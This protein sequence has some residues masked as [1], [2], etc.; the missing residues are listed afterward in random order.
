MIYG[1]LFVFVFYFY[2][3]QIDNGGNLW[4]LSNNFPLFLQDSFNHD[5]YNIHLYR[6][7]LKDVLKHSVCK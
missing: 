3:T 5:V 2:S 4:V 7:V 1:I 6:I